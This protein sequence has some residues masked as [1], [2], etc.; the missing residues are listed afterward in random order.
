MFDGDLGTIKLQLV[1]RRPCMQHCDHHYF[2]PCIP[3]YL[4]L[5]VYAHRP[6]MFKLVQGRMGLT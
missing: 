6:D 2:S 5:P 1:E 3:L 4:L